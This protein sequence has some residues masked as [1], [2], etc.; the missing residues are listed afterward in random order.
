MIT[1][2]RVMALSALLLA[3]TVILGAFAAHGLKH[4]L[5]TQALAWWQ[6]AVD[7]QRMHAFGLLIIGM[8]YQR[9]VLSHLKQILILF[10]SG[11][12]LFSGSLY[13][14]A[15]GFPKWLGAITPL[16]GIAWILGWF[17]L[18]WGLWRTQSSKNDE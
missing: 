9:Q 2:Q 12:V 8:L 1:P 18:A 16:G 14:M 11:I 6:T 15:L 10:L 7:Y 17:L 13:L 3:F 4:R 5:D